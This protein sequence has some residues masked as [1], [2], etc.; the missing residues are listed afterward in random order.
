MRQ[1]GTTAPAAVACQSWPQPP[2][3]GSTASGQCPPKHHIVGPWKQNFLQCKHGFLY[4]DQLF[5]VVTWD[6]LFLG[7]SDISYMCVPVLPFLF[8]PAAW[9]RDMVAGTRGTNLDHKV[10]FE[11]KVVDYWSSSRNKGF[12]SF[13]G[14]GYST[15]WPVYF[16]SLK[17]ERKN[18]LSH[19]NHCYFGVCTSPLNQVPLISFSFLCVLNALSEVCFLCKWQKSRPVGDSS[20]KTFNSLPMTS[21][22]VGSFRV[23][24]ITQYHQDT[25]TVFLWFPWPATSGQNLAAAAPSQTAASKMGRYSLLYQLR[26]SFS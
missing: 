14:H 19:L 12:L 13:W 6:F 2:S 4:L 25:K 1:D 10:T 26:K 23:C 8:L 20:N 22:E 11:N 3:P 5:E 9:K 24:S 17:W 18:F 7:V 21:L 15:N 16:Q